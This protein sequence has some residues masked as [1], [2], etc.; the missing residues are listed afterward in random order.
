MVVSLFLLY[1]N[2]TIDLH[3]HD[4]YVVIAHTHVFWLLALAAFV[5][6]IIYLLADKLLYSK[7]LSWLHIIITILTLLI[8]GVSFY[9]L[10]RQSTL[11]PRRYYDFSDWDSFM[12]FKEYD[13][14]LFIT[15]GFILIGQLLF[16]INFIIGLFKRKV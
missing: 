3:I 11:T 13:R 16:V 7:T 6:W 15:I 4:T 1:S 14:I 12:K 2:K 9:L 8:P 5:F 10:Q